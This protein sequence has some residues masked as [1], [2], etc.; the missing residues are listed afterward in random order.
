[1]WHCCV[2]VPFHVAQMTAE[3]IVTKHKLMKFFDRMLRIAPQDPEYGL[4]RFTYFAS[5]YRLASELSQVE[6]KVIRGNNGTE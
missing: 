2:A 3:E 5:A 1:M 6:V 4:L